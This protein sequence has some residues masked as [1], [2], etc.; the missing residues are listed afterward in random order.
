MLPN[1]VV[2]LLSYKLQNTILHNPELNGG[3][4]A[5]GLKTHR[6]EKVALQTVSYYPHFPKFFSAIFY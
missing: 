5:L 2:Q 1:G 4:T 6:V 3:V